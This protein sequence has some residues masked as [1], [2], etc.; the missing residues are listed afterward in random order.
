MNLERERELYNEWHFNTWKKN[1]ANQDSIGDA[2][3]LYDRVYS[4]SHTMAEYERGFMAWQASA[5]REGYKLV[6]VGE[7]KK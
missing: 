5:N 1:C 6:P 2:K 7:D 4:H 3:K